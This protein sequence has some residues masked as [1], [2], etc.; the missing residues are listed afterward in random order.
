MRVV[1]LGPPGAARERRAG[2]WRRRSAVPLI[3]TGEILR[4]AVAEGTPLGL[5]AQADVTP[6]GW[7]RTR[8]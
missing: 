3:S 4:E 2:G 5:S 8:W 7:C 1:L 6:G